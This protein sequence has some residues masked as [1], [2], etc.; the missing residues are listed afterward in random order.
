MLLYQPGILDAVPTAGRYLFFS[1][2]DA[3]DAR[4]A[5]QRLAT[6]ADGRSAV[7]GVGPAL[8][9]A[10]GATVPGLR[11]FPSLKAAVE[12]PATPG[13]LWCWLRGSDRGDLVHLT[14]R[15]EQALAPV[16]H[17]DRVIDSFRHGQGPNGHGRDLT[18]YEDGTEN[19]SGDDALDAAFVKD[20]G[21]GLDG[22]SLVAVQQWLHDFATFEAMPTEEQDNTI[23]RR[24]ADNGEIDDAPKSAHVKRTAQEDFEP[25]AFVLRRSMPWAMGNKAGLMFVAFGRS[26]DAFDAQMRRMAG[27]DDGIV[28]AVFRISRPL[29]GATYWCP[30]VQDG[31]LDW[32]ALGL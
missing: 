21:E 16:L 6:V 15:I 30:P 5:L 20:Q 8:V 1:L 17:L 9:A 18:G 13:A 19:P 28:D 14:R 23:G 10:V 24:R 7:V 32:R 12:V 31:R 3:S 11:D 27:L 29:T 25:E 4:G 22:G 26:L 2:V